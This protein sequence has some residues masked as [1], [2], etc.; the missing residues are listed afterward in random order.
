M[1]NI[2]YREQVKIDRDNFIYGVGYFE[3]DK[4]GNC[5]HV[6]F[7]EAMKLLKVVDKALKQSKVNK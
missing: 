6:P 5:K 4:D 7:D 2:P 1:N 3:R